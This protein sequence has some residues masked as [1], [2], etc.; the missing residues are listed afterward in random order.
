MEG[1]LDDPD[2]IFDERDKDIVGM[3]VEKQTNMGSSKKEPLTIEQK[4]EREL[5]Y[6]TAAMG[7]EPDQVKHW[8]YKL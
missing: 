4:V 3:Q 6:V 1:H 7:L 5:L 8:K 2:A